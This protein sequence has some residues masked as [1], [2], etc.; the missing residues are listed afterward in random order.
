MQE[1][2]EAPPGLR[3]PVE[4]CF[5]Q[6]AVSPSLPASLL[7]PPTSWHDCLSFLSPPCHP[8]L[9]RA[10]VPSLPFRASPSAWARVA[11]WTRRP[12]CLV[13]APPVGQWAPGGSR[14]TPRIPGEC[15]AGAPPGQRRRSP[16]WRGLDRKHRFERGW[17]RPLDTSPAD[18][19]LASRKTEEPAAYAAHPFVVRT[20][21]PS[22][23]WIFSRKMRSCSK[24]RSGWGTVLQPGLS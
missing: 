24:G 2:A 3:R 10:A 13:D 15:R 22:I 14:A 19:I 8:G 6:A 12:G 16:A 4:R 1:R 23:A 20:R 18:D 5:S 11:L 17:P 21:G 7:V 9:G